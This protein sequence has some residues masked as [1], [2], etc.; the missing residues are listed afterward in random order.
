VKVKAVRAKS[1][2]KVDVN[3]KYGYSAATSA[4]VSL[5]K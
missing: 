2:L 5:K 4:A 3:P 1:Q